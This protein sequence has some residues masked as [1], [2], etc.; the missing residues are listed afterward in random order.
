MGT[1]LVWLAVCFVW[2]TV[3]LFI[4]L[5]LRDVPPLS[6]AGVRLLVATAVLFASLAARRT[7]LPRRPRDLALIASTS[8]LLLSLNYGLLYWG[9]QHVP[10]GLTAV[11]QASTPAFGLLFARR[12]L[13][14]ERLTRRKVGAVALGLVGVAAIFSNE[15]RVSGPA[16]LAG[17]AAVAGGAGCVALGYV[18]V[19]AY[20]AHLRPSVLTAGQTLCGMVPLLGAALVREGNPFSVGWTPA[21]VGCLLYLALAGS[22]GAFYLN[23]WLLKRMDATKVLSM[24]LVEP[25]IAVLLGA[26]ILGERLTARTLL[27]GAL[28]LVSVAL[29]LPLQR[30]DGAEARK[31]QTV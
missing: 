15:L 8:F 26:A 25:L 3:W 13:P 9:A 22:V 21:A 10:S 31:A 14:G 11:L 4:K 27:G 17:S 16:A 5:G 12:F 19:K 18:L 28:I 2:S 1:I 30:G 20:G 24:A 6:F 29:T 7:P 23:Y